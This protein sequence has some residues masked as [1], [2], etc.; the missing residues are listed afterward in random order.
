M[1]AVANTMA[2][3][4]SG[5]VAVAVNKAMT[6][7]RAI[8][9]FVLCGVLAATMARRENTLNGINL[10]LVV[11]SSSYTFLG[12]FIGLACHNPCSAAF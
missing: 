4:L 2:A 5:E 12:V 3:L 10:V 11:V 6:A 9:A 8:S 7:F 1:G